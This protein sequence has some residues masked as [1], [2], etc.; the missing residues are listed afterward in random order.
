MNPGV[1]LVGGGLFGWLAYRLGWL[2]ASGAVAGGVLGALLLAR[3]EGAWIAPGLTFFASASLVSRYGRSSKS[4]ATL[5]T[6]KGAVRDA[7]QVGAN[8]GVAALCLVGGWLGEGG[9]W[10]MAYLG[11]F[12]TAAADTW[13]TE[14]G[15]L[16]R[17]WPVSLRTGRRV[18]PGTSGGVSPAGLISALAGA[19]LVALSALP[20]LPPGT[21][22]PTVLIVSGA[23]WL[24]ALVDSLLGARAQAQ[25]RAADGGLTERPSEAGQVLPLARGVR[26]LGNDAVNLLATASGALLAAACFRALVFGF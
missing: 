22:L 6:A 23:G 17:R 21:A 20:W 14:L 8:G 5:L 15:T 9:L 1:A 11:A 7:A 10:Y 16:A 25:Y 3:G 24:G 26:H 13:A 2:S 4:A 12:A 18:P 19:A